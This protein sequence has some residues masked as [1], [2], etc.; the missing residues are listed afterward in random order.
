[1]ESKP[2]CLECNNSI[3][4]YC[5]KVLTT[6][7]RSGFMCIPCFYEYTMSSF[8]RECFG[9]KYETIR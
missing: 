6:S 1:M 8:N 3:D 5:R 2:K 7:A 4:G 9:G